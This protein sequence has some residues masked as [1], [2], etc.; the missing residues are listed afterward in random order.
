M[1]Y[2]WWNTIFF[3]FPS[4]RRSVSTHMY[5][6]YTKEYLRDCN[7]AKTS[8]INIIAQFFVK[9]SVLKI[10][11]K[12][13]FLCVISLFCCFNKRFGRNHTLFLIFGY[14][15][16]VHFHTFLHL[17]IVHISH[18][19]LISPSVCDINIRPNRSSIRR[20]SK[21]YCISSFISH[22]VY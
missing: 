11:Y 7:F 6:T 12:N 4:Y 16:F 10:F 3:R 5:T 21:K 8:R 13:V 17:D 20:K 2:K 22:S 19:W 1:A 18:F 15:V 14:P 9:S